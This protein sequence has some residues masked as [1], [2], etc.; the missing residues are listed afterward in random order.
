[1]YTYTFSSLD[2]T[3][4]FSVF[5]VY[6]LNL[7]TK[8]IHEH[9]LMM[10]DFSICKSI[11]Y[12]LKSHSIS[13]YSPIWNKFSASESRFM[14]N[15]RSHVSLKVYRNNFGVFERIPHMNTYF[16]FYTL[17]ALLLSIILSCFIRSFF[18]ACSVE[19]CNC[20]AHAP[21]PFPTVFYLFK[22]RTVKNVISGLL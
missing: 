22:L 11:C 19:Y 14:L 1:M 12:L 10:I 20:T 2:I 17:R 21:S 7:C 3:A 8:N 6:A 18:P 5:L 9:I 16:C 15:I 13:S 4:T